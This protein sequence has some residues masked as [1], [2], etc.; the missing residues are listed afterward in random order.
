MYSLLRVANSPSV[1]YGK[2][3]AA[4]AIGGGEGV[5]PITLFADMLSF[6]CNSF[7]GRLVGPMSLHWG[8]GT[9]VGKYGTILYFKGQLVTLG[10]ICL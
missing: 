6:C 10:Y 5:R 4:S 9:L 3:A 7:I 1:K 8:T 2:P